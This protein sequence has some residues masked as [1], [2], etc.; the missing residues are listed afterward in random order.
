FHV[1]LPCVNTLSRAKKGQ[2]SVPNDRSLKKH[3]ARA[4]PGEAAA[5]PENA[6]KA[7]NCGPC[8]SDVLFPALGS[9]QGF[10]LS[11]MRQKMAK[12]SIFVVS[13]PV[14]SVAASGGARVRVL[15]DVLPI[16]G[17][18][19]AKGNYFSITGKRGRDETHW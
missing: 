8:V 18:M 3:A 12:S 13:G 4:R 16:L 1:I 19:G 2:T 7:T 14:T 15:T 17:R 6:G 9:G 11:D 10:E 5:I